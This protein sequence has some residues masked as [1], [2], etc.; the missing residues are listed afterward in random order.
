MPETKEPVLEEPVIKDPIG[1]PLEPSE[2]VVEPD[3][4]V[5]R[6]KTEQ[7]I[8]AD[9]APK[10]PPVTKPTEP[11]DQQI[12]HAYGLIKEFQVNGGYDGIARR[13]GLERKTVEQLH[14][15]ICRI[16]SKTK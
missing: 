5:L 10:D 14:V 12:E 7:Q 15:E 4:M 1:E 16:A 11:T 6:V 2:P 3:P 13:C 8:K 9:F